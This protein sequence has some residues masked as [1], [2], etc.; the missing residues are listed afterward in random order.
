[1]GLRWGFEGNKGKTP[2]CFLSVT[3]NF[4]LLYRRISFC[5]ASESGTRLKTGTTWHRDAPFS[6]QPCIRSPAGGPGSRMSVPLPRLWNPLFNSN[7]HR[8]DSGTYS[9]PATVPTRRRT[10]SACK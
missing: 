4:N 2:V 8:S 3:Q 1:M 10:L 5:M 9:L 6:P 7:P